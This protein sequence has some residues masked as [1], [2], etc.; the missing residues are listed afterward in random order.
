MLIDNTVVYSKEHKIEI[1]H[2]GKNLYY[3]FDYDERSY[4][5][6]MEFQQDRKSVV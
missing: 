6:N 1:G 2:P 5:I 3:Y 4:S